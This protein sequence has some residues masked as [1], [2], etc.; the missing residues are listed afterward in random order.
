M[1]SLSRVRKGSA[2][3]GAGVALACLSP[4]L[5]GRARAVSASYAVAWPLGKPG[6]QVFVVVPDEDEE[7]WQRAVVPLATSGLSW[8]A[9]MLG[10]V[11]AVRR[12]PLPTP[13]AAMML[14]GLVT[15]GDSLLVE[16][17]ERAKAK[18]AE[19]AAARDAAAN[20]PADSPA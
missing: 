17:G 19:A 8:T 9:L 13:V 10:L 16:V 5:S 3:R 12:S 20:A 14:G 1:I 7:P 4:S 11:S 2:V 6:L 18:M 15:V